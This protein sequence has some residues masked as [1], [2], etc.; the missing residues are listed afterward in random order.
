M[1]TCSIRW[2]L[3]LE[4]LAE[5]GSYA[6]AHMCTFFETSITGCGKVYS[7]GQV[8]HDPEHLTGLATT[9]HPETAGELMQI[10]K[11]VDWL[12]TS[13]PRIAGVVYPLHLFL[14]GYLAGAKSCTKRVASNR[15]ISTKEWTSGLIGAGRRR[16][17]LSPKLWLFLTRNR[18]RR[19]SCFRMPPTS[20]GGVFSCRCR[21]KSS[22]AT[23]QSRT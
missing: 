22:I 19:C 10:L 5:V 11:V 15:A 14:E 9:R 16:R 12:R 1:L 18:D 7:Q 21:R 13:W 17:I 23:F 4:P 3:I 6:A 2:E 20:I 8:K